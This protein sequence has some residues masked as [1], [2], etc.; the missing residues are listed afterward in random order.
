VA[1]QTADPDLCVARTPPFHD[2][3]RG[4]LGVAIGAGLV[5]RG[6]DGL[7]RGGD[8]FAR[9]KEQ[10]RDDGERGKAGKNRWSQDHFH[11]FKPGV[12]DFM[13]VNGI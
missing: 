11:G 12:A 10:Q 13:I 7:R 5:L 4:H 1:I 2:E 6:G 3:G 8:G 9:H